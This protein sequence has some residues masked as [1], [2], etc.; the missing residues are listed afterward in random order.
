MKGNIFYKM[1]L[2]TITQKVQQRLSTY[3]TKSKLLNLILKGFAIF[4]L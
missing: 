1:N 3:C 4:V 2:N